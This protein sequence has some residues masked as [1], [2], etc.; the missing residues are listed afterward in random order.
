[1]IPWTS[2]Q[3]VKGTDAIQ[4]HPNILGESLYVVDPIRYRSLEYEKHSDKEINDLSV[5]SYRIS[6]NE[7]EVN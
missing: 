7:L 3:E 6:M 4:F 5:N 2:E 1:M